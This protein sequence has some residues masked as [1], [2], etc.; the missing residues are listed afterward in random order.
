MC[1][2]FYQNPITS[3]HSSIDIIIISVHILHILN[4]LKINPTTWV[5]FIFSCFSSNVLNF[6]LVWI[7]CMEVNVIRPYD[8]RLSY[9]FLFLH[10]LV[11][12]KIFSLNLVGTF[13]TSSISFT[14]VHLENIR[15]RRWFKAQL[16][17]NQLYLYQLYC[18]FVYTINK[19]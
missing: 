18:T 8:F 19:L 13:A 12:F 3:F 14:S 2:Y 15:D 9:I 11:Q 7:I 17:D 16:V 6:H 10:Y 4:Y 5:K 1:D